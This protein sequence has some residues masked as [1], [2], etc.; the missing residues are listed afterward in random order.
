MNK[1]EAAYVDA[2]KNDN[3][4]IVQLLRH[5][6]NF[7][8][9]VFNPEHLFSLTGTIVQ[10]AYCGNLSMVQAFLKEST[11]ADTARSKAIETAAGH[12]H[13][14]MVQALLS[15]SANPDA[16]RSL[17]LIEAYKKGQ[18]HVVKALFAGSSWGFTA[19]HAM[20]KI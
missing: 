8:R 11:D 13:L 1:H 6:E 16:D 17:A 18:K 2:I 14:G 4:E 3:L 5:D 10:A 12:G 19:K 7:P 20:Y 15:E 9:D